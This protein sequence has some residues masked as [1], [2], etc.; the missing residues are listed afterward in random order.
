MS[1]GHADRPSTLTTALFA[2]AGMPVAALTLAIGVYLPRHFASHVGISL[3][4]VGSAFAIV[5][6]LD[7]SVDLL[8]GL[9]MDRTRTPWGRYR[10]WM[11]VGAPILMVAVYML[12]IQPVAVTPF[13]LMVWLLVLYL[14]MS[15]LSL[16][17]A[18]WAATL[19]PS[20]D[21]R[22]RLFGRMAAL[23]IVGSL[24]VLLAPMVVGWTGGSDAQTVPVMG[25]M[26]ICATPVVVALA[27]LATTERI[28]PNLG[29][30]HVRVQ[31]YWALI[32]RPT[33]RRILLADFCLAL[34]PGW[35]GA[36]VLF[37]LVDARGFSLSEATLLLVVATCSGF[38]GAPLLSRLAMRWSKHRALMLSTVGYA[39]TLGA[40]VV[41]PKGSMAFAAAI[42]F[43]MGC[44]NAGFAA[45]LRAMTADVSDELRLEQNRERAG[46]L[47]ALV[48]LTSKVAG[49]CS[50]FLTFTVL[51]RIGYDPASG[52]AN[53][54][55]ALRGLEIA[56]IAGPIGF[57]LLGG[58]CCLGYRLTAER[59]AQIRVALD[60]REA[61]AAGAAPCSPMTAGSNMPPP[62][63][64][65]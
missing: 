37:F 31:D 4:A 29:P 46:L 61:S 38:V 15:I 44:F 7:I 14:G 35:L 19:A 8:L 41:A 10:V 39:A 58:L 12:F 20:Y 57:V 48:T 11:V 50:I 55:T 1:V 9:A 62:A 36:T 33:M 23:G 30:R 13:T 60:A 51:E 5:R 3:A 56:S 45:L 32:S 27:T 42:M 24:S 65:P 25:W 2:V 28:R 34:G 47:Y 59:H 22:S 53:T 40:I 54:A 26:I 16:A 18:A 49:A 63:A 64:K 52:P 21:E 6:L 43:V 17:H